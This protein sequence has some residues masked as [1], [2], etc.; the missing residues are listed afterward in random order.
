MCARQLDG[1]APHAG[2]VTNESWDSWKCTTASCARDTGT[3][4]LLPL[5]PILNAA[6]WYQ[7]DAI[8]PPS[9]L[10]SGGNWAHWTNITGLVAGSS[11]FG[12]ELKLIYT[13]DQIAASS[14]RDRLHWVW[15]GAKFAA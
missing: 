10:T 7:P 6:G 9:S 11:Q 13:P 8:V 1:S 5:T 15:D 12:D 3:R 14:L 2:D 4:K